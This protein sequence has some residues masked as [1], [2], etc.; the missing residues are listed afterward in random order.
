MDQIFPGAG[1]PVWNKAYAGHAARKKL[2]A[3]PPEFEDHFEG[4]GA[5]LQKV[6]PHVVFT[7]VES[8]KR[9]LLFDTTGLELSFNQLSGGEREIAFLVGQI[10][11][12][13]LR[14]GL[15]LLDEPELHLN[16]DLIRTWVAFLVGSVENGQIW[17]AT[18]SLEAVEAAG[19]RATFVL[20]RNEHTR[21]VDSLARL[22]ERPVLSAL[23]RAVGTPAFSI[24]QLL[25]VFVEGQ[26]GVGERERFR[27]LA[28]LP[29]SVRFMECGSCNEVF[30]RVE[31]IKTLANESEAG[32]RIG[33]VVD[34]DFRTEADAQAIGD[35][36][37]VLVLSLHEVENFFLHPPTLTLL[38]GQ[39]GRTDVVATDL[40]RRSADARA[41]SWIFQH[42][43]ATPY[44]N[45]LPDISVAAK[46]HA[47]ALKWAQFN[48]DRNA[49]VQSII[50][51]SRYDSEGKQK[52]QSILHVSV[53]L[54]ARQR[55]EEALWKVCE[56]KQVLNDVAI[57]VG[58]ASASAL[59]QAAFVTWS[60][61]GAQIPEEL[62]MFRKY[63][64]AL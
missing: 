13:G 8:K 41:G 46:E 23:S 1:E 2:S 12:F 34:R 39:N 62:T 55:D 32:I 45:S 35:K 3:K 58:F 30:R 53:N 20:E 63:L 36:Q 17:L 33:G 9:T 56:G 27:R 22:D 54:Y 25:F 14:R 49:A 47:K 16:A 44:A 28:G 43:M 31:A 5:A 21:K 38:L 29:Q 59:V 60:R 6:L 48:A 26:E 40:I 51:A 15:F 19:Q 42:A 64:A 61:E 11:R 4:Y 10:D 50:D 37:G 24:S 52:L 18:H 7:G 57:G